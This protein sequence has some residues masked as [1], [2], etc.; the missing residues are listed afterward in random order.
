MHQPRQLRK[1]SQMSARFRRALIGSAPALAIGLVAAL[2]SG[3][4]ASAATNTALSKIHPG[5]V[6]YDVGTHS[7]VTRAQAV[8]AAVAASTFTQYKA[9]VTVGTK[10]YTY[11]IAG[12][13]PA[14]KVTNPASTIKVLLVPLV[15][16]FT[17][18]DTWNPT[19]IDSCDSGASALTRTQNSPLFK[20]QSW[21]WGGTKIGTGQVTDAFQRAEFWKYANPGGINPGFGINLSVT[22]HGA[23]TVNV[24]KADS[25]KATLTCGNRL[26]GAANINWLDPFLQSTVIPS[27]GVTPSTVPIF[28]LHN[29]VEYVGKTTSC[30]VIGYHNAFSTTAGIQTYGLGDYDN[31]AFFGSGVS[32]ISALTHE[33]GEWQ[34]DPYTNNPTPA[35]GNV[36][37]V[38]GCQA[39][40]EVADPLSGTNFADTINGFKYHVQ[41]QAFFSWFY[42]QK[43]S[44]GVNGWYSNR[45]TFKIPAANCPPGGV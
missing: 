33:V 41:E 15:M 11:V 22:T 17:N 45:G 24:P 16:K 1:Q 44:L 12:K 19:K 31:G 36:G 8:K 35:W 3:L 37:Q 25:A 29:F 40:L 21:T 43:P 18:G 13:N 6:L 26:E 14:I 32:D 38:T 30:C 5:H 39:N 20:S 4:A 34:N 42:H 10:K 23:V 7:G 27:L 2:P 9:T 28:L